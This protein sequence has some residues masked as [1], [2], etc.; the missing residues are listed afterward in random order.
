MPDTLEKPALQGIA[1]AVAEKLGDAELLATAAG[2]LDGLLEE[3]GLRDFF[4]IADFLAT[5]DRPSALW[6]LRRGG[7]LLALLKDPAGR[8]DVLALLLAMGRSRWI[9]VGA[10]LQRLPGLAAYPDLVG[11][12]LRSAAAIA[13]IDQDVALQYLDAS[14]PVLAAI[15]PERFAEWA[16]LGEQIARISWKSAREYFKSSPEV[17]KRIDGGDLGRWA[18]LGLH[19]LVHSPRLKAHDAHSMLA[20]GAAAGKSKMID[21]ALQYFKAAPQ[22]LARLSMNDL[23]EWVTRGLEAS[24]EHKDRGAAYFSLQTGSSRSA[25]EGL[26]KGLELKDVHAVLRSYAEA[27]AGRKLILRSSSLF[28]KNLPGLSRFFSV[29]DGERIFLPSRIEAFADEELNFMTYKWILTHELGHLL[30]GTFD[31]GA[32]ELACVATGGSRN[33]AL[34]VFEFLEDER[35]DHLLGLAYPGLEKDRRTLLQAYRA[36]RGGESAPSLFEA[37]SL[38]L[39][40]AVVDAAAPAGSGLG[41]HLRAARA[42]AVRP[43]CA[44]RDVLGIAVRVAAGAGDGAHGQPGAARASFD[45]LFYRGIIDFELVAGAR[46]GTARLVDEMAER[47]A[48]K[49]VEATRE[50]VAAAVRSIEE[51]AI[52]DSE[53]L[54]WQVEDGD[55]LAELFEQ[56]QAVIAE[57]EAE[58]RL[59]RSVSYDEWDQSIGDYRKDWCRVREMDMAETSPAVYQKALD[60]NY[61]LVSLLRRHFGLLRPDRVK[62]FFREERG[63]D[64]DLDAVVEAMVERHAG[65]T[66]SDRIYIRR[67]KNL[68]DVSVAF[69]LD[70]SYSTGDVLASGKRIIDIEREGMVLMA[71]A[72]E[73]IGDSWAVFGFSSNYRDKVDFSVVHDFDEPFGAASKSR[74]AGIVP[75]AQTRLGAAIRH[76]NRLLARRPSRIRLLILL[77]DGRPYDID[78]GDADYGVEDTRRALLEGRRKGVNSFCITVDKKSR[79]YLP[80]MYGESNYT[81]IDNVDT[82]PARLPLIYK[83]LTT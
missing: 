10:A 62:R 21:L 50:T 31:V 22:I 25:V 32:E 44:A 79:D 71:E 38:G 46:A 74:F 1:A 33:L 59:R 4:Q 13:D 51:T 61:G 36:L 54:L 29:T 73:S 18:R 53:E 6:L 15:G 76:T 14:L 82:L 57:R 11:A 56:V 16:D 70:M 52:V 65:I 2:S 35:V 83:R 9:V 40:E 26:V 69:L 81:V 24:G 64:I 19:L 27:L 75:M 68:R 58:K 17:F 55:R 48:A 66:P 3:A 47:L 43:G 72:L 78:Y 30:Y 42:E 12:W 41:A 45:R 7:S 8:R 28:Y 34:K 80:H 67:E 5:T 60:E 49:K 77:S 23:E 39:D 20:I 37:L 63:D